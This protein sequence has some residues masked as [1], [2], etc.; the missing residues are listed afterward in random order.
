LGDGG[1]AG[2][3]KETHF[4]SPRVNHHNTCQTD[5]INPRES[6][7]SALEVSA[8]DP[9]R[10]STQR[11]GTEDG[12]NEGVEERVGV[13]VSGGVPVC[14]R[15]ERPLEP[16]D[17]SLVEERERRKRKRQERNAHTQPALSSDSAIVPLTFQE[18]LGLLEVGGEVDFGVC[19]GCRLEGRK[20]QK[21]GGRA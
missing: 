2:R 18:E 15:G 17:L 19:S 1:K 4:L 3:G 8:Y 10:G 7:L 14:V 21:R 11:V 16:S 12:L 20:G 9:P 13:E 6:P 5:H